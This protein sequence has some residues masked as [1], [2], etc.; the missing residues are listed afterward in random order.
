[1]GKPLFQPV[2]LKLH[3]SQVEVSL[4]EHIKEQLKR[5]GRIIAAVNQDETRFRSHRHIL[6]MAKASALRCGRTEVNEEDVNTLKA[7]SVLWLSPYSGDEPSFRIMLELSKTSSQ[8]V[9]TLSP[10]YSKAT[11][12]RRI[13]KLAQLKAIKEEHGVWY[14]NL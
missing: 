11:V 8:L 6:A 10:L 3:E 7:L 5:L 2:K 13:Q 12:Y 14:S 9:D 4:S 1:M